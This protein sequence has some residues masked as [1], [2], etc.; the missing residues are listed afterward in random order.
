[1]YVGMY[2][3]IYIYIYTAFKC[4][5]LLLDILEINIITDHLG[6][7]V[8]CV[9]IHCHQNSVYPVASGLLTCTY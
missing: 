3:C 5:V 1:M 7:V 9:C 2:V 4:I 8:D 6:Y